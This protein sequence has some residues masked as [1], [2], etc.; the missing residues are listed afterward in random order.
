MSDERPAD[1]GAGEP[2]TARQFRYGVNMMRATL[3]VLSAMILA[4]AGIVAYAQGTELSLLLG[5]LAFAASLYMMFVY[6]AAVYD[7]KARMILSKVKTPGDYPLSD[8]EPETNRPKV[9]RGDELLSE[10][11]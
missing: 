5:M 4:A 10:N 1:W 8:M 3:A 6:N 9:K 7:G 11:E 2:V